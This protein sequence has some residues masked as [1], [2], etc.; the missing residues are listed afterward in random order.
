MVN[1][2]FFFFAIFSLLIDRLLVAMFAVQFVFLGLGFLEI[3]LHYRNWVWILGYLFFGLVA[4][5]ELGLEFGLFV[6]GSDFILGRGLFEF[7]LGNLVVDL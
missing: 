6:L 3:W 5:L 7:G 1:F 4:L 2:L